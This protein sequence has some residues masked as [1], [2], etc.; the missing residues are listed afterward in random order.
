[1][2]CS[3]LVA[4]LSWIC[5]VSTGAAIAQ[6]GDLPEV[7]ARGVLRHLGVPYANFVVGDV[8]GMDVEL[9]QMFAK[10]LGVKYEYVPTDWPEAFGDLTGEKVKS[11]GNE[12]ELLAKVPIR[13]DILANGVTILAW[14]EKVASF[15]RPTF[16]TQVWL[17]APAGSRLEPIKPAGEIGADIAATKRLIGGFS[18]LGKANT[19]LEPGLYQ[20]DAARS[21]IKLFPGS[22]N[23]LA[24]ALL[25]GDADLTLLD[26]PDALVALEKWPGKFKILGPI[27]ER[28]LMAPA[29]RRSSPMLLAEL[30]SFLDRLF[31]DGRFQ[32]LAKKYYPAAS[33]YFPEFFAVGRR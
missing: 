26:V 3:R 4:I 8:E 28:Q 24:P 30:N 10:H 32:L 25:R 21:P 33:G 6:E 27:S 18:L 14:R 31:A 5:I 7:K 9:M 11:R 19:C 2:S 13:G 23:E 20:I 1:M 15:A 29:L 16:P 22:L 17:I 12:V